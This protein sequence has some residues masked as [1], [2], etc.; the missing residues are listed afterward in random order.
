[1]K[2]NRRGILRG[3]AGALVTALALLP[4]AHAG[5]NV[6]TGEY[7]VPQAELQ[8]RIET[9]FPLTLRYAQWIEVQVLH[10][11]LGLDAATGRAAITMDVSVRSPL[12]PQAMAGL[13]TVSSRLRFDAASRSVRL[14]DPDADRIVF[15]GLPAAE[16]A[17]LQA[18]GQAVAQQALQDY[19]VHTFSPEDLRLGSRVLVPGEISVVEGAIK[20]KLD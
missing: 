2:T 8:A 11:R 6:W 10:P 9:R 14:T 3:A 18:I 1:M 12:S 20:V 13:L 19:P 16:A 5:Y 4:A 15:K 17:Q 7:T